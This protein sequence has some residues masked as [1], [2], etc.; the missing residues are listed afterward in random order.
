VSV[1]LFWIAF[2]FIVVGILCLDL[3]VIHRKPHE[4]SFREA[5]LFTLFL[6]LLALLF[7]GGLFYFRGKETGLEFLT[8][9]LIEYSLSI[10]NLFVFSVVFQSYRIPLQ[11]EHRVLFWGVMGAIFMRLFFIFLGIGLVQRFSWIFY[12]FAI[13]LVGSGIK[14]LFTKSEEKTVSEGFTVRIFRKFFPVMTNYEGMHFFVRK[15]GRLYATHLFLALIVIEFADLIFAVD[16]VPA[17]LA[18]T[19]DPLVV[20]TSN[21]FAILGLRSLY[22]FWPYLLRFFT[23]LHYSLGCILVFV[24]IKI[25]IAHHYKIPTSISLGVIAIFILSGIGASLLLKSRTDSPEKKP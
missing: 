6:V 10:D 24:G 15:D 23:Y 1:G 25:G 14:I 19:T 4:V 22:S 8:G 20:V 9:Y 13:F 18:I 7:C 21:I 17:I 2:A 5:S 11:Y 12:L 3:F 16:S